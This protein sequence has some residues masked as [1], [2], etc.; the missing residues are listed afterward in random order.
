MSKR[1]I[2]DEPVY[3]FNKTCNNESY[4]FSHSALLR[5]S[6]KEISRSKNYD[7]RNN[8]SSRATRSPRYQ[9]T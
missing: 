2:G 6:D 8:R 5:K 7:Y 1:Q 9:Q 3:L 4:I